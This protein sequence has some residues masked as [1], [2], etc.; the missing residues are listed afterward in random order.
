MKGPF[1]RPSFG[2]SDAGDGGG[3]GSDGV[4]VGG[5]DGSGVG[6]PELFHII[7]PTLK[8]VFISIKVDLTNCQDW[9]GL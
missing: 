6:M 4:G 7:L 5:S 9:S 8:T 2:C 1:T 3:G